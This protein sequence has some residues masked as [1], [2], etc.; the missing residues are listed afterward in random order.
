LG[1]CDYSR[2]STTGRELIV[3]FNGRVRS[4]T[5]ATNLGGT[6]KIALCKKNTKLSRPSVKRKKV[7]DMYSIH[8]DVCALMQVC[9]CFQNL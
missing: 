9:T 7:H 4:C 3:G 5:N 2:L 1:W 8:I 6:L